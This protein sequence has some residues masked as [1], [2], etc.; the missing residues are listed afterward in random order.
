MVRQSKFKTILAAFLMIFFIA[1]CSTEKSKDKKETKEIE[2][3]EQNV[4]DIDIDQVRTDL[5][6]NAKQ[7]DEMSKDSR[8]A[9]QKA[10]DLAI[11]YK[12]FADYFPED[13]KSASY[14]YE[15]A[16][17]SAIYLSDLER[18]LRLNLRIADDYPD[19]DLAPEALLASAHL[20]ENAFHDYEKAEL[21]YKRF[22]DRYPDHDLYKEV[23]I[24]SQN[25]GKIPDELQ[26]KLD[27]K[28]N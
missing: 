7:F 22:L 16:R 27:K 26:K 18:S 12:H 20:L 14:L 21:I 19:D 8:A 11:K 9:Q 13:K 3:Q 17:I 5:Y 15:A 1:A 4:L 2:K 10:Y 23:E 6:A 24:A 28:H 25:V